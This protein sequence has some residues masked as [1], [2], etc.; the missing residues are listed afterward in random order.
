MF[1]KTMTWM[2]GLV[3][4][5]GF[6]ATAMQ[7][8]NWSL[9]NAAEGADTQPVKGAEKPIPPTEP[10]PTTPL[11]EEKGGMYVVALMQTPNIPSDLPQ[12]Q[13]PSQY[14]EQLTIDKAQF[15]PGD[16][17]FIWI[18]PEWKS[19]TSKEE[20][21]AKGQK[22]TFPVKMLFK[23]SQGKEHNISGN[24][25]MEV[26]AVVTSTAELDKLYPPKVT[27]RDF[28]MFNSA[29]G[30]FTYSEENEELKFSMTMTGGPIEMGWSDAAKT[31][32]I[33][34][35]AEFYKALG[36]FIAT[37]IYDSWQAPQLTVL[38][39]FRDAVMKKSESGQRLVD[40]YY[41]LGPSWALYVREHQTLKAVLKPMMDAVVFIAAALPMDSPVVAA[42]FNPIFNTIDWVA[43][44]WLEKQRAEIQFD[45]A[46]MQP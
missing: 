34:F 21:F 23:D 3:V 16:A 30:T 17:V 20:L 19:S 1:S 28:Y 7:G 43:T 25:M 18:G 42:V 40:Q 10:R 6:T 24:L 32:N 14:L 26:V 12:D 33:K 38:R 15:V 13:K 35:Y 27:A 2:F 46:L 29:D 37:T 31:A 45:P 4:M 39:E 41:R 44:P 9:L 8:S 11:I 5:A 36:C 22:I